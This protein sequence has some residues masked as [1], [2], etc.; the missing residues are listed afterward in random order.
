VWSLGLM[1][2]AA[3]LVAAMPS[4]SRQVADTWR[5]RTAMSLL[6]GFIAFV[7]IPVAALILLITIVGIPLALASVA[8]YLALLLAGYVFTGISVGDWALAR[9]KPD[10]VGSVGW[11]AAAA[12]LGM[13]SVSLLGRLPF[14]GALIVFAALLVGLGALVMQVRRQAPAA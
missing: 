13:L 7:C 3:V 2:I 12:A 9:L 11:R 6:L 14:I 4:V 5:T 8:L 1:L 10:R